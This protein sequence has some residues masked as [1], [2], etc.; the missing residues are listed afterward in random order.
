MR[1][2]IVKVSKKMMARFLTADTGEG[3]K[4]N[5]PTDLEVLTVREGHNP[6]VF[7]VI[8]ESALFNEVGE[9]EMPPPLIVVF[10]EGE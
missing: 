6:N 1:T 3:W 4:S 2:K 10:S 8:C 9:Y 7:E 5:A